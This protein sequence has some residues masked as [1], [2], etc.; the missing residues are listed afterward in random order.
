[1]VRDCYYTPTEGLGCGTELVNLGGDGIMEATKQTVAI[2]GPYDYVYLSSPLSN[3][4][5]NPKLNQIFTFG[6]G[7]GMFNPT[8]FYLFQNHKF[9]DIYKRFSTIVGDVDGY[10]DNYDDYDPSDTALEQNALMIPGAWLRYLA[11]CSSS[12]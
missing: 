8:R 9:C 12:N 3:N 11:S 4:T 5:A 10:D 1:M 6:S 7:T 2:N